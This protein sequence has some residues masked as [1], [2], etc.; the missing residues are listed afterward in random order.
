[1]VVDSPARVEQFHAAFGDEAYW[2][3]R[4]AA[5]DNGTLESFTVDDDGTVRVRTSFRLLS[6][7]LPQIVTKLR[8]GDWELAHSETWSPTA[9]GGVRGEL[10]VDLNGAPLSAR[11]AGLLAPVVD[12]SHLNYTVTVA[13]RVPL[14]GG[15]IE[16]LIGSQVTTWIHG[17]QQ[18]TTDWIGEHGDLPG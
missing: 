8:R 2:R 18:F 5:M 3:T 15:V 17:I 9:G 4:L 7:D 13:V 11:G 1:M 6:A 14:I 10:T 16:G 12:G